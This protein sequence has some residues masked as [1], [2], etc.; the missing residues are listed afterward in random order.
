MSSLGGGLA[1]PTPRE[2]VADGPEPPE[3]PDLSEFDGLDPEYESWLA[4]IMLG[5]ELVGELIESTAF[6]LQHVISFTG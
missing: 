5:A 2:T 4:G 3:L 1:P 6:H